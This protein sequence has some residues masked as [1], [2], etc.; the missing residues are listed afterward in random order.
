MKEKAENQIRVR[1]YKPIQ[2]NQANKVKVKGIIQ[3][4]LNQTKCI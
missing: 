3:A 1:E 4:Q 2:P